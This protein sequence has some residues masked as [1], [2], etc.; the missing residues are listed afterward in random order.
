MIKDILILVLSRGT[1]IVVSYFS[2]RII[3]RFPRIENVQ[4][5]IRLKP[6]FLAPRCRCPFKAPNPLDLG[7]QGSL[8]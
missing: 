3:N 5:H 2:H 7:F 4:L 6:D 1:G 8:K